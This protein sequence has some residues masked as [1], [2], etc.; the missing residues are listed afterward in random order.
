MIKTVLAC[1]AASVRVCSPRGD[2]QRVLPDLVAEVRDADGVAAGQK[3][4]KDELPGLVRHR[5]EVR[6][7]KVDVRVGDG[8]AG[9]AVGDEA[10]EKAGLRR[11]LGAR[12][13]HVGAGGEA[14]EVQ[15]ALA[16]KAPQDAFGG[17]VLGGA[18]RVLPPGRARDRRRERDR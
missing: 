11:Q 12:G 4:R 5:A 6:L 9:G 14:V 2:A 18:E 13:E 10:G 7:G 17:F 15:V 8:R 3:G 1:S 16:Q